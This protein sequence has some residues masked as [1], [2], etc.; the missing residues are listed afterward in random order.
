M[1]SSKQ[2]TIPSKIVPGCAGEIHPEVLYRADAIQA[3]MGWGQAAFDSARKQGL[4]IFHSGKRVYVRGHDVIA[5]VTKGG[6]T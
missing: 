4:R 2:Q 5:Y 1:S 3:Q 6:V